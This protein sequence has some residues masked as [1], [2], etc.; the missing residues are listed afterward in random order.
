MAINYSLCARKA[1]LLSDD[2]KIYAV[3]QAKDILTLEEFA[4]HISDHNSLY[5]KSV[6]TGVLMKMVTCLKE[7]LLA[8]NQV[9]FGDLGK[10][11]ITI[12][13]TGAETATDYSAAS[14]INK[15]NVRFAPG[16]DLSNL[17]EE[18]TLEQ[19]TTLEE[20]AAALKAAKA[21]LDEA[22]S[23]DTLSSD[24]SSDDNDSSSSSGG[25]SGE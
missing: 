20:Q 9:S 15:L 24:S 2:V 7:Q 11:F 17:L 10:F 23:S 13:S 19:T 3:A 5:D 8:G 25:G 18:A 6:I 1:G 22:A 12:S 16:T 4:E 21:A 14:Y